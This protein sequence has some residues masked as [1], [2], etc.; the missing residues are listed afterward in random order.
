MK[1]KETVF[2]NWKKAR[3]P[4][5]DFTTQ[6]HSDERYRKN[7]ALP[8]AAR[9]LQKTSVLTCPDYYRLP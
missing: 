1:I 7:F 9:S 6:Q 8:N 5:M 3:I 2:D 4:E